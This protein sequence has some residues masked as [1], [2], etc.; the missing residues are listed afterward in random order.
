[1]T[2]SWL[3]DWAGLASSGQIVRLKSKRG[4]NARG[5]SKGVTEL[6]WQNSHRY[7]LEHLGQDDPAALYLGAC[8][9]RM[10][11][12]RLL[13]LK[14][15][16]AQCTIFHMRAACGSFFGGTVEGCAHV[17]VCDDINY[18]ALFWLIPRSWAP[19]QHASSHQQSA[20]HIWIASLQ[21][22]VPLLV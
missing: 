4:C 8:S 2:G 22:R 10:F 6:Q 3:H 18:F 15:M 5:L 14:S 16:E 9:N 1:M 21:G 12:S 17:A 19:A 7:E 11:Y 20:C 13:V